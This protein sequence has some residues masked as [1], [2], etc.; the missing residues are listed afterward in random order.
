MNLIFRKYRKTNRIFKA[1]KVS[2]KKLSF[3]L[4]AT[5]API[6]AITLIGPWGTLLIGL[7]EAQDVPGA[8]WD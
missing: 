3:L 1:D 7:L 2:S 5:G 8:V 6:C 4:N